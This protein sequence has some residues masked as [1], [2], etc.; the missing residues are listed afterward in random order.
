[1]GFHILGWFP[2]ILDWRA[3][4]ESRIPNIEKQRGFFFSEFFL[5]SSKNVDF[6]KKSEF[7]RFPDFL[8][9]FYIFWVFGV[10][11]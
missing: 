2:K 6:L 9:T 10:F 3:L 1:M 11:L 4:V 5:L 8:T 7:F